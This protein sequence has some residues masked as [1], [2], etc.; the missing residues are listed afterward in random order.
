MKVWVGYGSE[1]SANLVIVGTFKS[2]ASAKKAQSLLEELTAIAERD[3]KAGKLRLEGGNR[4]FSDTHL[5]FA[6]KNNFAWFNHD[7]P[8]QL[9]YEN[10]AKVEKFDLLS[11]QRKPNSRHS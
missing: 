2:E 4:Q 10:S 6:M 9:L 8:A 7:D 11:P 1:H 3:E 5:D